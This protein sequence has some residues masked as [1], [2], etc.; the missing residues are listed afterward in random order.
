MSAKQWLAI[1]VVVVLNIIV[2]GALI[3]SPQVE[4]AITPTPTWTVY[5]TFTPWPYPTATPILMPTLEAATGT[6]G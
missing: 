5:P 2:F 6:G 3:G 1:T 4:R